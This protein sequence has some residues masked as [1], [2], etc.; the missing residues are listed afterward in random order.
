MQ[1]TIN[2]EDLTIGQ[3]RALSI[4]LPRP[5]GTGT[6]HP[7]HIGANY[8]IR[9][10]THH[11]TGRIVEVFPT[12]IVVEDAAWIADDGR[13]NEAIRTGNFNEVETFPAGRVIIGRGSLIDAFEVNFPSPRSNK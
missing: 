12:E 10:V 9:T 11:F 3:L 13:F 5:D 1:T 8:F 4:L 7:F 6:S 2:L